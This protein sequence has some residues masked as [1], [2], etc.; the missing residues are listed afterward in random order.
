MQWNV[1]AHPPQRPLIGLRKSTREVIAAQ[2]DPAIVHY[3][4]S[5]KPW[6]ARH[7]SR[8]LF[9]DEWQSFAKTGSYNA[10]SKRSTERLRREVRNR[11]TRAARALLGR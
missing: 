2:I 6:A 3:A 1:F 8:L 4:G 10:R 9:L 5:E 7:E 11:L